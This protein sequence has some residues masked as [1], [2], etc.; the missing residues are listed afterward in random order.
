[1]RHLLL[2]FLGLFLGAGAQAQGLSQRAIAESLDDRIRF[3]EVFANAH[4]GF[5]LYD[6][7][8][9]RPVYGF[10]ADRYFVP[11]SN[12]KLLTFFLANRLLADSVPAL[13]YREYTD[14]IELW[15]SGYPLLLHPT[16]VGYDTLQTWLSQQT[17]PLLINFPA[18]EAPPRYGAGWSW[19]DYDY[20]Y[21]YERSVLPVYGNRLYLDYRPVG[22]SAREELFGS[23]SEVVNNLVQD[24]EQQ[25]TITRSE[26]SNRFTVSENFYRRWNF[27]LERSLTVDSAATLRYLS[28]AFPG[29]QLRSDERPRPAAKLLRGLT[30]VLPDTVYRKLLQDSDNF[31]AEQLVLLAATQ[32][33]GAPDEEHFLE[34]VTDTLFREMDLG[35]ISYRDGSGLSRYNLIQP[36]QL[37]Q[38]VAALHREVGR[39]RLLELLPAGGVSGTLK[40]RFGNRPET[41]VWAKTGSLSGVICIS[42]LLRTRTDRW[43]AF[44]FLHNNVMASSREYYGEMEEI[45][46]W[47]YDNL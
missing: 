12:N 15:G 44:S 1:M 33:Y 45:L 24:A 20:G 16:F 43:L 47:V 40:N 9:E 37:V 5:A 11:A 32:R 19:D 46:A 31:L 28:D 3:S 7:A 26:G 25:R 18:E 34:W 30:T 17:K 21:V 22:E 29:L 8:A 6:I 14:R 42:G 38:I 4:T 41:Y 39:E 13:F 23:P 35:E 36:D 27:P 2:L 10:Q